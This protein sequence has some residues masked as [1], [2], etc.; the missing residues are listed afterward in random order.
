[1]TNDSAFTQQ[2]LKAVLY[3]HLFTLQAS[4]RASHR[5]SAYASNVMAQRAAEFI[6]GLQPAPFLRQQRKPTL[7]GN[8]N[9]TGICNIGLATCTGR[10]SVLTHRLQNCAV[11]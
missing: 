7:G 9:Q 6:V 2:F 11:T 4:D 5:N 1:M 3:A 8:L 10:R